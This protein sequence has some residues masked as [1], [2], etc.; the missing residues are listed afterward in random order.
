MGAHRSQ[1]PSRRLRRDEGD[2]LAFIGDE[3]RIEAE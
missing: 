2:E 3:E 1:Q